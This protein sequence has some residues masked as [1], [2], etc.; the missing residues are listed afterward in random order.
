[1]KLGHFEIKLGH[2]DL[3]TTLRGTFTVLSL[4]SLM[5]I[6]AY[7]A[8]Y[9]TQNREQVAAAAFVSSLK[10]EV[11][12]L[13][14]RAAVV[15]DVKENK[16]LFEKDAM[17][18][19]PLASLT[20]L[21][22]AEA[23]LSFNAEDSSVAITPEALKPEGDSG[24]IVGERWSLKN[25][26]TMGLV[27]SSNDAMAAAAGSAGTTSIVER[28]NSTAQM[29]GLAHSSFTNPTGLDVTTSEAGAYGTA[30]DVA[31]L[32]AD[33]LKRYP[34][35][36]AATVA[37]KT[38]LVVNGKIIEAKPTAEPILDIPGLIGAKTGYTDLAGGNL[39]A[40]FDL[41]LGHPVV[42]VVLGSSREG[43]FTDVRALIEATRAA[44]AK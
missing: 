33:F 39:V 21:M 28:M 26:L 1:M 4:F 37:K 44:A 41:E 9:E 30:H 2:L 35:L 38:E 20:K 32:A 5:L 14:A 8:Q 16:I 13:E 15:Y 31:L 27:A 12:E 10:L 11:G 25:L 23:I 17:E 3:H 34:E 43:R 18:S 24:L 22:S 42:V 6:G 40:A 36:F 19:W 7:A 29:L